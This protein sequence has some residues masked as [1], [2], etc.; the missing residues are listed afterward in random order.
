MVIITQVIYRLKNFVFSILLLCST[1]I[2][3]GQMVNTHIEQLLSYGEDYHKSGITIQLPRVSGAIV[4]AGFTLDDIYDSES[5]TLRLDLAA[6]QD[7][8]L[9]VLG[10]VRG[11]YGGLTWHREGWG[12]TLGHEWLLD[13][14]VNVPESTLDL[15]VDGNANVSVSTFEISGKYQTSHRLS[16]G[17]YKSWPKA[18]IGVNANIISGVETLYSDD[19]RV[20]V[21]SQDDFFEVE[22]YK[23]I[24]VRSSGVVNYNSIEDITITTDGNVFSAS[25]FTENVGA[26]LSIYAKTALT[27]NLSIYG[28]LD[29]IGIVRWSRQAVTYS[30]NTDAT[31]SGLDI[32]EAYLS[33][34]EYSVRDTLYTLLSIDKEVESF[35]SSL[36]PSI[37]LGTQY[38]LT[39]QLALEATLR[40]K[41]INAGLRSIIQ[42]GGRYDFNHLGTVS[43]NTAIAGGSF[44]NLGFGYHKM[45]F[46]KL[47]V[48]VN[49]TNPWFLNNYYDYRYGHFSAGMYYRLK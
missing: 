43:V 13:A 48:Y 19:F 7:A 9:H 41:F 32:R 23:E 10:T 12:I 3:Q 37:L 14:G 20:E 8:D 44:L 38:Q 49:T 45:I 6:D 29:D 18:I 5:N 35:T 33:D 15:V 30:D 40:G 24:L 46:D 17:F 1:L 4:S 31:Y 25:P 2:L 47:G 11:S 21:V 36:S 28:M 34:N 39:E 42:L 22:L 27:D 16:L 26:G